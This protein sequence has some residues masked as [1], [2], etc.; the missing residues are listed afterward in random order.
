MKNFLRFLY[1][2][3]N[4]AGF[5]LL[6]MLVV[7]SVIGL[8]TGGG[9]ASFVAYSKKQVLDQ[10]V[11]DLKTGIDH[12]KFNAVS[13]VKPSIGTG[14]DN[15]PLD[16]YRIR[17][18][19][20]G[21]A[22]ASS[23]DLYEIDAGCVVGGGITWTSVLASKPRP[24]TITA[25][26]GCTMQFS[27]LS[28]INAPCSIVITDGS[29]SKTICVDGGGNTSVLDG[30][31]S[32]GVGYLQ[33]TPDPT[34]PP[35]IL[36]STPTSIPGP[37]SIIAQSGSNIPATSDLTLTSTVNPNG[38]TVSI[39]YRYSATNGTCSSL[40]N[41]KAG[42][43]GLTGTTNNSP[44]AT[45]VLGLSGNTTYYYCATADNN[46]PGGEGLTQ[47]VGNNNL[48]SSILT[49]PGAPTI[50]SVG[51]PT[52][53]SLTVNWTAPAGGTGTYNLFYCDRTANASCTPSI[54]AGGS[55]TGTTTSYV[56]NIGL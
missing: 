47:G 12:A 11:Q 38:A 52:R 41:T 20:A 46:I 40:A 24:S 21:V 5:T 33:V 51:S 30:T 28:G 1:V 55:I 3:K 10:A 17:V 6:E 22:C 15:I 19:S 27:V 32:C 39:T 7:F 54:Q 48:S 50:T 56:H 16:R 29:A 37:P 14:C 9:F 36:L 49:I 31:P 44:N 18:C 42:P 2:T 35:I 4:G 13:R 26:T 53:T 45:N 23:A 8:L 34:N 43:T 25:T